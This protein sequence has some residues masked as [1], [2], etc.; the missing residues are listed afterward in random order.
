MPTQVMQVALTAQPKTV[1]ISNDDAFGVKFSHQKLFDGFIGAQ[2]R[3]FNGER[4]NHQ[5]VDLIALKQR[6]F[7]F[8]TG[9]Q[10]QGSI[11]GKNN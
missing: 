11:L 2:V 5:M 7:F 4:H 1:V 8:G 10:A 6:N 9:D 3:K